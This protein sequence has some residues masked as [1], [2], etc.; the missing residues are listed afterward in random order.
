MTVRRFDAG[1]L[2]LSDLVLGSRARGVSWTPAPG[3]TARLQVEPDFRRDEPLDLYYE[4]YG[5]EGG[6]EFRTELTLRRERKA[7]LTLGFAERASGARTGWG[8][9]ISLASVRPG[10]YVL[11]VK[12]TRQSGE[13]VQA[14]RRVRIERQ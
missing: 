10:D 5:L 11:E 9:W 1:G 14:S 3:D 12:V 7:A 13:S 6:E 2:S 8:R 4:V